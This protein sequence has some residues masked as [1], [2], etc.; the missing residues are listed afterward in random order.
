MVK[1]FGII[2]MNWKIYNRYGQLVFQSNSPYLGWDGTFNGTA[3]PVGVY[4]YTLDATFDNGTKTTKK[5]D[6]TLIR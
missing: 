4:A 5:G 2:S 1:G 3:Q 6:I